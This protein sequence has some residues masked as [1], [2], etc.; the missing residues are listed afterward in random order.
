MRAPDV[1]VHAMT[2]YEVLGVSPT[3]PTSEVRRAYVGLARRHHPDRAGGDAEAMRAVNDAWTILRDP[4]RRADYDRSLVPVVTSTDPMEPPTTTDL[5]DLLADLEDDTPLGGRV[6]LPRWLSLVPVGV[7][8][9]SIGMF[10]TGLL[11]SASS[12]LAMSLALFALSCVL[13]LSAPFVAL[14]ASRR[15]G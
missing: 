1:G 15:H 3:A 11:F 9:A 10:V 14:L 8:V 4:V 12:A 2:H 5:E 13:F 7:F 6:V